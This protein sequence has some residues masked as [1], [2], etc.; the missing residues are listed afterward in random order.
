MAAEIET[1]ASAVVI[2]ASGQIGCLLRDGTADA[3]NPGIETPIE[4]NH[5]YLRMDVEDKMN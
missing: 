2:V 4:P 1:G 3:F 5:V